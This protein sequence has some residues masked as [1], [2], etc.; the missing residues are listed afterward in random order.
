MSQFEFFM[1]FYSLLLGLAV[2][3]L[4]LGFGNLLRAR[5]QP[6]WGVLTP[7]L[8][9]LILIQ[10]IATFLDAWFKLQDIVVDMRGI[11][12]P[13]LIG[14]SYFTAALMAVPRDIEDWPSFDEY[15][16]ARKGM[17]LGPLIVANL[18]TILVHE[19]PLVVTDRPVEIAAYAIVNG[20]LLLLLVAPLFTRRRGI[21]IAAMLAQILIMLLIYATQ[22]RIAGMVAHLLGA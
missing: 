10:I 21:A 15:F 2:A 7:L 20:L 8:G 6:R 12:A 22:L 5:Q 4:L 11:A 1:T 14:I 3:E 18:L 13:T 16:H 19:L 17:T 9:V